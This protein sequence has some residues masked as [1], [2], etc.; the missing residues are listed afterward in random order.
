MLHSQ[1]SYPNKVHAP[2]SEAFG[3]CFERK[4]EPVHSDLGLVAAYA[5][6]LALKNQA[7]VP[8]EHV[9]DALLDSLLSDLPGCDDNT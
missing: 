2:P 5:G 9:L 4:H 6:L 8:G 3:A 7:R 1:S